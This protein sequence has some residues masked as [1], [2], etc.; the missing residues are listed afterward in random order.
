[1]RA[2]VWKQLAMSKWIYEEDIKFD[3]P[4]ERTCLICSGSL[5]YRHWKQSMIVKNSRITP[6][7]PLHSLTRWNFFHSAHWLSEWVPWWKE[8]GVEWEKESKIRRRT[9]KPDA[10][11][12]QIWQSHCIQVTWWA[13]FKKHIWCSLG[14]AGQFRGYWFLLYYFGLIILLRN[15]PIITLCGWCFLQY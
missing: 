9:W 13:I 1:M 5:L 15:L 7:F 11:P 14:P 10:A 3:R 6:H 4:N 8:E 12:H 2:L